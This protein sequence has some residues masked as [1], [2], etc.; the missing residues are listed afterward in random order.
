MSVGVEKFFEIVEIVGKR[1]TTPTDKVKE[2]CCY[3]I[4]VLFVH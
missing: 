1:K 4:N 2:L 3:N